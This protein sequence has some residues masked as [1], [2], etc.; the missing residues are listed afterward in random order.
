MDDFHSNVSTQDLPPDT[1][2]LSLFVAHRLLGRA[3]RHLSPLLARRSS[4]QIK[5]ITA[6][7]YN[8][9]LKGL[10]NETINEYDK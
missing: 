9:S 7:N 6:S 3:G 10:H 4:Q 5:F 1:Q 2:T 8:Y